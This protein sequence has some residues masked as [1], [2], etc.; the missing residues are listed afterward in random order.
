MDVVDRIRAVPTASRGPHQ[1]VPTMP[2]TIRKATV[3][4]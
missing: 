1:N 3:E 4:N 2:I